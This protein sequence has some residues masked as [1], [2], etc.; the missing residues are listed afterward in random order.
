MIHV[1]ENFKNMYMF[2]KNG[3]NCSICKKEY[4]TLEHAV[5]KCNEVPAKM[6]KNYEDLFSVEEETLSE[7]IKDFEK[8]WRKREEFL[9]KPSS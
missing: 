4:E 3:L 9:E 1:K 2:Q 7:A 5:S 6:S 8:V